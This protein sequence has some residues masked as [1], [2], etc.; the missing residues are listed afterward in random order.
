MK[1]E[2][3]TLE[4]L[5]AYAAAHSGLECCGVLS[6]RRD[7]LVNAYTAFQGPLKSRSFKLPDDWLLKTF[8]KLRHEG[9]RIQGFFHSHPQNS[10]L[11]PSKADECGHP[12]G[13]RLLVLGDDGLGYEAFEL[14]E[15]GFRS[16]SLL[17]E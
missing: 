11:C 15:S 14:T 12:V 1:I 7:S 6:S 3:S 8:L 4:D 10:S 17:V 2:R 16:V 13:S 5:T 9:Y